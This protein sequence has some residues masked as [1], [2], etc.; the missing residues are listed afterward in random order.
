MKIVIRAGGLG[1][2]LWPFSRQN[3][4]KQ[5]Q[6]LLGNK[7]MIRTTYE[8]V[9]RLLNRPEDLFI[10]I[11]E[12][13]VQRLKLEIP[14][15]KLSNIIVETECRNTGPAMCLE[16]CYLQKYCQPNDI[17]ASIPSDDYISNNKAFADLL[18]S[19][20]QFL[21]QNP[22]Y[23][24]TP[25][26]KPTHVNTGYSYLKAGQNLQNV[27]HEVI[28]TVS[29][30][31]EKPDEDYC[32]QLINSGV[33][34]CH[35]GMYVWR[36]QTIADLFAKFQPEMYKICQQIADL[37]IS[38]GNN[39]Q[40]RQLYGQ[41]EKVS[42]ESAITNKVEKLA[43]SVSDQIG[44]SDLGKWPVLY[45]ILSDGAGSN[46]IKGQVVSKDSKNNLVFC[47]LVDKLVVINDINNL[48]IVD[49]GDVLF[50]SSLKKADDTKE[51]IED[52]KQRDLQ[53]Y[54]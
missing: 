34:Y 54:I 18:R 38:Y 4:P 2:R 16:V 39:E 13:M 17:I 8:R 47:N 32:Q 30:V 11:N 1:V 3:N 14:E 7:T 44:W 12:L 49:T 51:I 23:I 53:K 29:D 40:I 52:L 31:V 33:Y 42:I 48:V 9:A 24:L 22:D 46:V 21:R 36:L 28:F 10:S 37:L 41:L 6:A 5:F 27:G 15:V 35:T 50:I 19:S 25:A 43:M 45:D 26:T 20:E